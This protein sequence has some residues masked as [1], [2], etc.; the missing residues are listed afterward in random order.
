VEL[1][2]G[3]KFIFDIGSGSAERISALQ[4]PYDFLDKVFIGHLHGDHFGDIGALFVGGGLGGRHGPL[5]IW[6]P[7]GSTPELGTAVAIEH[8]EKMYAWDIAGRLG[9]TDVRGF[10]TEVHEFDFKKEQIV[11]E[12]NGVVIRSFPAIHSIDGSVGF[13][14]EWSGL[15]FV[16]GS[17]TFPN[18][19][20][21]K[22]AKDADLVIHECFVA[23]PDLI[24]KMNLTP[25]A[26]LQVGTQI[27]TA[28]EAF[29]KVMSLVKPRH[30]VAYH[31]FK[32][33]DTTGPMFER[34]R[35]TYDGPLSL[36]EDHMVWNVTKDKITERMAI[37]NH[38]TWVPPM[39]SE[40]V[41][42][43]PKDRVGYSPEIWAG[44]LDVSDVIKPIYEEVSEAY[45]KKFEYP[46]E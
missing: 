22:N 33:P 13:S 46:E 32:D 8:M 2:N 10:T 12:E 42:P 14:L 23:V 29:G 31:F 21:I 16:F 34:I 44:R 27:H 19:W 3:E 25:E 26:A 17:D 43:D 38:H 4:I 45:G 36:A 40:P 5:R 41:A 15:K 28:P 30:A 20:F 35:T 39:A 9:Q 11:Y 6:G 24:A 7:S 18:K 1:G 37:V